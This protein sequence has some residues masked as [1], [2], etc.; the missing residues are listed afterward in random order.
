MNLKAMVLAGSVLT[1]VIGAAAAPAYAVHPQPGTG[2]TE[3]GR[4]LGT[5]NDDDSG[6]G[7]SS[8]RPPRGTDESAQS[9]RAKRVSATSDD[10]F[11]LNRIRGKRTRVSPDF[12]PFRGNRSKISSID[13]SD[14]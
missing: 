10:E 6:S 2:Q 8:V 3:S 14:D 1:A 5:G 9:A 7:L 11:G 12:N 13:D 4:I